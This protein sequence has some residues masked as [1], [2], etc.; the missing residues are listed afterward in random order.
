MIYG[1]CFLLC[2][3]C[4]KMY[5]CKVHGVWGSS[6]YAFPFFSSFSVSLSHVH[7]LSNNRII[8]IIPKQVHEHDRAGTYLS[9][10]LIAAPVLQVL[11]A[12]TRGAR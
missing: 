6:L 2:A 12:P 8:V 10:F 5:D 11:R 7:T 3:L 9:L 1:L 4:L